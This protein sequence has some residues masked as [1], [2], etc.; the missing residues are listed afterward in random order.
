M[1]FRKKDGNNSRDDKFRQQADNSNHG[2]E[3]APN[4]SAN[5]R[6]RWLRNI[7]KG[8]H[9]FPW[10]YL[11]IFAYFILPEKET[12]ALMYK[13][14]HGIWLVLLVLLVVVLLLLSFIFEWRF[15]G[16]LKGKDSSLEGAVGIGIISLLCPMLA[17]P[18]YV[19]SVINHVND[20]EVGP[21]ITVETYVLMKWEQFRPRE[22]YIEFI[23]NGNIL[24]YDLP[25]SRWEK[26]KDD[27]PISV[28]YS[29]GCLNR[30]VF[31]DVHVI[32]KKVIQ[33]RRTREQIYNLPSNISST[34]KTDDDKTKLHMVVHE[35][36]TVKNI[37]IEES[38]LFN[39]D[40]EIETEIIETSETGIKGT[41]R[42]RKKDKKGNNNI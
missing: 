24:R 5:I 9:W 12:F 39:Y 40:F 41:V 23:I 37:P 30:I 29:I 34:R 31:N 19:G 26:F 27:D 33:Q 22:Y 6:K 4:D 1:T 18:Y 15:K 17:L 2:Q 21:P 13:L 8:R 16:T 32:D 7:F 38:D 25:R 10:I 35:G 20:S 3:E 11:C 14:G 42:M 36:D 28:T